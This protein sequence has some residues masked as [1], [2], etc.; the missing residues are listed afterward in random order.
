MSTNSFYCPRCGKF[1]RHC[2]ISSREFQALE[3][4][5]FIAQTVDAINDFIGMTNFLSAVSGRN[6]YKCMDCVLQ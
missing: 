2:K 1:T 3:G 5:G 6:F 4:Y